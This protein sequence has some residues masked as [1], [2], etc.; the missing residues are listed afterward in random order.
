MGILSRLRRGLFYWR[1]DPVFHAKR[2]TRH[3]I[4]RR[5]RGFDDAELWS[6]NTALAAHILPRLQA[7][8]AGTCGYPGM[9]DS[10]ESWHYLLDKMIFA[11]DEIAHEWDW[12]RHGDD[13]P[14]RQEL[15]AL[16]VQEGLD[17]FARYYF[18]L[19]I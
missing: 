5:R 9:L 17:L 15:R 1:R 4:Q 18:D 8:R 14:E 13:T 19:W 10:M 2:G 7:F 16:K 6:L 12:N 11:F 3:F